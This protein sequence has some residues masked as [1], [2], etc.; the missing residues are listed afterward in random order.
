MVLTF[1]QLILLSN[2]LTLSFSNLFWTC[3]FY[4]V[5]LI[6]LSFFLLTFAP[7]FPILNIIEPSL[8]RNWFATNCI[9]CQFL[10]Q[11]VA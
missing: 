10:V 8:D 9:L 3:F 11:L 4:K 7:G 1:E 6:V 5:D 2:S